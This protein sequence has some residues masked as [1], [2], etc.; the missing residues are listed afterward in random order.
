MNEHQ[1]NNLVFNLFKRFK[2]MYEVFELH[3]R[4]I[5]LIYEKI[6]KIYIYNKNKLKLV[7]NNVKISLNKV[8]I[9]ELKFKYLDFGL[10][11]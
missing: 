7:Y 9:I 4:N 6:K 11:I 5:Q 10:I 2:Q 8:Y 3:I 1:I